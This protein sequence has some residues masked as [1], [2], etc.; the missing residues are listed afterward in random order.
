MSAT[1]HTIHQ[2]ERNARLVMQRRLDQLA[3]PETKRQLAELQDLLDARQA[4]AL[5][6]K[7]AQDSRRW[8]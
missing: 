4:N 2:G 6:T 5:L 1:I 3:K 8:R 7:S